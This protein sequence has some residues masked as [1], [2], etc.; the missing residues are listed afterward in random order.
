MCVL[1][2]VWIGEFSGTGGAAQLARGLWRALLWVSL[3]MALCS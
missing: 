1:V 3:A 2:C